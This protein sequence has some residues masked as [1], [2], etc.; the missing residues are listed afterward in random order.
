MHLSPIKFFVAKL[1][2]PFRLDWTHLIRVSETE[3]LL[4]SEAI[5]LL[6]R[7]LLLMGGSEKC[8][9]RLIA[10][11]DSQHHDSVAVVCW[12]LNASAL[13]L[14]LGEMR[15]V[16]HHISEEVNVLDLDLLVKLALSKHLF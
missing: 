16:V 4:C 15:I 1:H 13:S 8:F 3:E 12:I 11:D 7:E 2:E 10:R 14:K 9:N 6:A 5:R